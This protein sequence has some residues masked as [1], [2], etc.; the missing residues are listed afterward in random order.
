L[1][2][3]DDWIIYPMELRIR[4][5][6]V[7]ALTAKPSFPFSPSHRADTP[8]LTR[9]RQYV[10]SGPDAT[11]AP[12]KPDT[13]AFFYDRAVQQDI[14]LARSARSESDRIANIGALLRVTEARDS[15]SWC[16]AKALPKSPEWYLRFR[17]HLLRG[18]E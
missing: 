10:C 16:E 14:A 3:G 8:A 2:I 18:D 5:A 6:L 4:S 12:L 15:K 17:D 9:L 1:N 7:P 13:L 11:T